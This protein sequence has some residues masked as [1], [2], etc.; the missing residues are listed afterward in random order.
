MMEGTKQG[1]LQ[2]HTSPSTLLRLSTLDLCLQKF[3]LGYIPGRAEP[4][5]ALGNR[6]WKYLLLS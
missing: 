6:H 3:E 5:E 4:T 2:M 1:L